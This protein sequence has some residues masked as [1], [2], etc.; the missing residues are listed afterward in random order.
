M[1]SPWRTRS[2]VTS[3]HV[4][5][6]P[7]RKSTTRWRRDTSTRYLKQSRIYSSVKNIVE[8]LVESVRA[9]RSSPIRN[10]TTRWRRGIPRCHSMPHVYEIP[11]IFK[12]LLKNTAKA[13]LGKLFLVATRFTSGRRSAGP[14]EKQKRRH[15]RLEVRGAHRELRDLLREAVRLVLHP[16][17][18]RAPP[19]NEVR[20][21]VSCEDEVDAW[22]HSGDML[23]QGAHRQTAGWPMHTRC[24]TLMDGVWQQAVSL[25]SG[26]GGLR[27]AVLRGALVE[28]SYTPTRDVAANVRPAGRGCAQTGTMVAGVPLEEFTSKLRALGFDRSQALGEGDCFPLSAMA[29][30]ELSETEAR[31]PSASSLDVMTKRVQQAA[32]KLAGDEQIDGVQAAGMRAQE[33]LPRGAEAALEAMQQ[34]TD[35]AFWRK[36]DGGAE[37]ATFMLAMALELGRS[38]VVFERRNRT[39]FLNPAKIYGARNGVGG[40]RSGAGK[41][42]H[43]FVP[44]NGPPVE[45]IPTFRLVKFEQILNEH[46]EHPTSYS[47]MEFLADVGDG[48][49][50]FN[51]Y[52]LRKQLR[53]AAL[54]KLL[55]IETEKSQKCII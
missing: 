36:H 12:N 14:A 7:I 46:D 25:G 29:G 48:A 23:P 34:W 41:L 47:V 4:R 32:A 40:P 17:L 27:L 21:R 53:S 33:R 43:T 24:E 55:A 52:I 20:A 9:R 54:E 31:D 3:A 42:H 19:H 6:S 22:A 15:L 51:P 44:G 26:V 5:R 2:V 8:V 10:S 37:F 50:H 30:F 13:L 11:K 49:R 16:L 38:I 35:S 28:V 1:T 45:V 18:Q 39:E